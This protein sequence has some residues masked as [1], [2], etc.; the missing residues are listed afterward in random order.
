V[1]QCVYCGKH[2]EQAFAETA[3]CN[4]LP[5]NCCR[6]E[7]REG[8][9]YGCVEGDEEII[10][11]ALA[12]VLADGNAEFAQILPHIQRGEVVM[13]GGGAGPLACVWMDT[14]GDGNDILTAAR[15]FAVARGEE[16]R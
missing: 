14:T 8:L 13:I 10:S 12:V 5:V 6:G 9:V 3:W 15:A 7:K 11:E 16:A 4:A 1:I 2:E